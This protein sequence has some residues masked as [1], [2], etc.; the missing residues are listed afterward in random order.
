MTPTREQ[1]PS[2]TPDPGQHFI[3]RRS[4]LEALLAELSRAVSGRPTITLLAGEPGIGKTRTAQAFA[5][6]AAQQQVLVLWGRCPEEPGAPPYW[7]WVQLIRRYALQHNEITFAEVMG[8]AAPQIAA[9]DPRTSLPAQPETDAVQARFR[10]FDAIA[11][12]WQRAAARQPL[13]LVFDDLHQADVPS[14]KLL[15][16]VLAEAGR[17]ALMILATYRDAEI[18][19]QHPLADSLAQLH[20]HSHVQ[21][22]LLGGFSAA[23][24]ALFVAAAG[25]GSNELAL[26]LHDQTDGHPLFLAE[27]TRDLQQPRSGSMR[28]VPMGVPIG[29]RGVIGARLNRLAPQC[30]RVLQHAA[31]IGRGF[32]FELLVRLLEPMSAEACR[33]ALGEAR[34]ASLV[35]DA[36]DARGGPDGFQFS[37]ALV[38]DALYNDIPA[39][40]RAGLHQHVAQAL[41][42]MHAVDLTPFLSALAH[43]WHAAGSA[44]DVGKAVEYATR[45][46]Q[47]A[48][49]MLAHEEAA[50]HYRLAAAALGTAAQTDAQRCVLLLGQGDAENSGGDSNFALATF[51]EAAACARRVGDASLLSRAAIGF[52]TAQWRLGVDG[53]QAVLLAREALALSPAGSADTITQERVRLSSMLCRAL[54]FSNRPA[55]AEAAFREAVAM[56]RRL[57]DPLTLFDALCSIVPGRWYAEGLRL[58]IEAAR[59]GFEMMRSDPQLGWPVSIIAWHC[60]DLMEAGDTIGA[61]AVAQAHHA[62]GQATR[63]PVQRGGGARGVDD[64]RDPRRPL[65]SSRAVRLAVPARRPALR[66]RQRRRPLRG[67]DVH[68]PAPPGPAARAGTGARTVPRQPA[69][70][71]DLAAGPRDR[72]PRTG[73]ARR[74]AADLRRARGERLRRP[75]PRRDPHRQPR[76]PGRGL[77]VARR[78]RARAAAAATARAPRRAQH[79]LWRAHRVAGRGGA[80]ARPARN[81]A[82]ALA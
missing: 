62:H 64:D 2:L 28:R 18:V 12:F 10:L 80:A 79:R 78:P 15:E 76:L 74:G 1:P 53:T 5:H 55:E 47:H 77:R 38:R 51:T 49:A 50:R 27:L 46:A 23:E 56:A 66:P 7:P 32:G 33:D 65:G 26:A 67:A 24:S 21:R 40:Q 63:D 72:A 69:A 35:E 22:L 60:G 59:E 75:A 48:T 54:L 9:L 73:R 43:H 57:G 44:G 4:E 16:F 6:Q 45:A 8:T 14:L 25:L 19:R 52:G 42:A 36:A 31:V 29:V 13:L 58:R 34:A 17:S 81:H 39:A 61:L 41:E 11:G 71:V 70:R 68:D 20:R 30:S 82:R 3:G 37:H